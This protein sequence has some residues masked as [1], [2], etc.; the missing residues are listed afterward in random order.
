[1]SVIQ[2]VFYMGWLKIAETVLNPFG[3]DDDDWETNALLDRNITVSLFVCQSTGV[4][5]DGTC[6]RRRGTSVYA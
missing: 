5:T 6:Y 1:M 3:E 4:S 2:F